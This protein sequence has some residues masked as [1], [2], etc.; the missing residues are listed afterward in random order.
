MCCVAQP[1]Q[2]PNHGQNGATRSA[3]ARRTSTVSLR[4]RT[5]SPGNAPGTAVPSSATPSP[6]RSSATISR[7]S[8]SSMPRREKELLRPSA[9][10]DR[11]GNKPQRRPA[12]PFDEGADLGAG[13]GE[14]R[15]VP[16][17]PLHELP[18]AD[19][20]LRLDESDEPRVRRRERQKD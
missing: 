4:G 11:R 20:E 2:R 10:Q 12:E 7:S 8:P 13:A 1:P 5:R 6:R 18:R 15:L 19:L 9:A 3:L 16:D 17:P 14:R